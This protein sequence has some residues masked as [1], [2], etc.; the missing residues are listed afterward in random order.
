MTDR[1]IP[2]SPQ[3]DAKLGR[4]L[5]RFDPPELGPG[6]WQALT[7]RLAAEPDVAE[8]P[9][10]R[11]RPW[12]RLAAVAAAAAAAAAA[13]T[14][15][16]LVGQKTVH[17]AVNPPSAEAA[18]VVAKARRSLATF[19]TLRAE[20]VW[21][22]GNVGWPFDSGALAGEPLIGDAARDQLSMQGGLDL[23]QPRTVVVT[24]DG[25]WSWLN[26]PSGKI[27][28][29]VD[30]GAADGSTRRVVVKPDYLTPRTRIEETADWRRGTERTYQPEYSL[31]DESGPEW[32]SATAIDE[33]GLAPGPPDPSES[34]LGPVFMPQV[35]WAALERGV[36]TDTT[37]EG[38]PTQTVTA[39]V[40]PLIVPDAGSTQATI[41]T[42]ADTVALT[43]DAATGFP[44]RTILYLRGEPTELYE[45]R[46]LELDVPVFA[47]DF[48]LRFPA[49]VDVER[50]DFGFRNVTLAEAA[51][52]LGYTPLRPGSPPA[53]FELERVAAAAASSRHFQ[54]LMS[55]GLETR[56]VSFHDVL[57]LGYRRGFLH[58]TVTARP[59]DGVDAEWLSHPFT[60]MALAGGSVD[61]PETVTLSAGAFAGALAR[62]ISPP[63]GSPALWVQQGGLL[64]TMTGDLSRDE[65]VRAAESLEPVE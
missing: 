45:L 29:Y 24:A 60:D 58:L 11:R 42:D 43:V 2:M 27:W 47:K 20:L 65:L 51:D 33:V 10:R 1:P 30:T 40:T 41:F 5:E 52:Q 12:L 55:E 59:I 32:S 17:E 23:S 13:I 46:H 3:P 50:M 36:V 7:D 25:R 9:E 53:G 8:P 62:L 19:T 37:F 6:F 31:E 56:S 48:D 49:G 54:A 35:A 44:L 4:A 64:V 15:I 38:R 14:V 28:R 26:D 63:L 18:R 57:S 16:A 34:W 61:E 21:G 39:H 22:M